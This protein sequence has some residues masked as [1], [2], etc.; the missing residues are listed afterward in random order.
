[1][2][3]KIKGMYYQELITLYDKNSLDD[4]GIKKKLELAKPLLGRPKYRAVDKI[5]FNTKISNDITNLLSLPETASKVLL[6]ETDLENILNQYFKYLV[7]CID[8]TNAWD[9]MKL[10]AKNFL[11]KDYEKLTKPEKFIKL[12]NINFKYIEYI[13]I[14]KIADLRDT[15]KEGDVMNEDEIKKLLFVK[16]MFNAFENIY[17]K[18]EF[19]CF[20]QKFLKA[21]VDYKKSKVVRLE[22]YMSKRRKDIYFDY[23]KYSNFFTT[24]DFRDIIENL[25]LT[26]KKINKSVVDVMDYYSSLSETVIEEGDLRKN[27][28]EFKKLEKKYLIMNSIKID[29]EKDKINLKI[30]NDKKTE[31]EKTS[32]TVAKKIKKEPA[33]KVVKKDNVEKVTKVKK[34]SKIQI[35]KVENEEPKEV[36]EV[37]KIEEIKE[38]EVLNKKEEK[39]NVEKVVDKKEKYTSLDEIRN[40]Q[41]KL[42]KKQEKI[43]KENAK[44]RDIEEI[45]FNKKTSKLVKPLIFSWFDKDD[46]T[47]SKKIGIR[48]LERFFAALRDIERE[49]NIVISLYLVTN[50]GKEVTLKR[51]ENLK[52]K[53]EEYGMKNLV[54][55][56]LGGYSSFKIDKN[57]NIIDIA[58]MS[59]E[60]RDKIALLL[61]RSSKVQLG[62][63]LINNT[64]ENYLRYELS[65]KKDLSITMEYLDMIVRRLLEDNNVRR[66]PL[67]FIPYIEKESAGIDVLLE[68]QIKGISQLAEYYKIKYNV[69]SGRSLQA[70]ANMIED[71][72]EKIKNK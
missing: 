22:E 35:P 4:S 7:E 18:K 3:R 14:Q 12:Y 27:F 23:K 51:L 49:N 13:E 53:S 56:A 19:F 61:S 16:L 58:K 25:T 11:F 30:E 32:N 71:F 43:I 54:E 42:M 37:K 59:I 24:E 55:G 48:N 70:N 68:S 52:E 60:N 2:N 47:I 44:L 72:F 15:F 8:E 20:N 1:M 34:A 39:I 21:L 5:D 6:F 29:Y 62:I 45:K 31:N 50:A 41:E 9:Y 38:N 33:I 63:D 66:Q 65:N 67:K 10:D 26:S 40:K 69:I 17:I 46:I 36:K 28:E 57:G 64:E